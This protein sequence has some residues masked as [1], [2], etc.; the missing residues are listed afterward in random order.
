[1]PAEKL[2]P[3]NRKI[4]FTK[5]NLIALPVPESGYK[6]YYDEDRLGL[7]MGVGS[8]GRKTFIFYRKVNRKPERKSLGVFPEMTIDQARRKMDEIVGQVA[9]DES[10]FD[11]MRTYRKSATLQEAFTAYYDSHSKVRNRS[12]LEDLSKFERFCASD[13]AGINLAR[14]KMMDIKYPHIEKLFNKISVKQPST[15]NRVIALLSSVFNSYIREMAAKDVAVTNPVIAIRRNAEEPRLRSLSREELRRFFAALE[16]ESDESWR[17]F[18][19]L[20]TLTG[21]RRANLL[22]LEKSELDMVSQVWV[23]PKEKFKGKREHKVPLSGQAFKIVERQLVMSGDSPYLFPSWGTKTPH[24]NEPKKAWVRI[25]DRDETEEI[26]RRIEKA[27]H[28][29]DRKQFGRTADTVQDARDQAKKLGVDTT[30]ARMRPARLHDLRCTFG[31]IQAE[32][33]ANMAVT[34]SLMGHR[35]MQ[36]T[37]KYYTAISLEP[38]RDSASRHNDFMLQ[39]AGSSA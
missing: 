13:V 12:H 31:S 10:P 30:G 7:A 23:I 1:M 27:G 19:M 21:A 20:A 3:E 37:Q 2:Q 29:A 33:G 26:F 16:M 9:A 38:A 35:S 15:A 6:Y 25:F 34:K 8:S 5:T 39:I 36:T 18:F 22:S 32:L 14:L 28:A 24:L 17:N 4:H 11:K